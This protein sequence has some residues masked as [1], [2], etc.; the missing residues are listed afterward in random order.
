MLRWPWTGNLGIS[1]ESSDS[2]KID[3]FCVVLELRR[4]PCPPHH[5]QTPDHDHDLSTTQINTTNNSHPGKS[6]NPPGISRNW[7]RI[8]DRIASFLFKILKLSSF[9]GWLP[10]TTLPKGWMWVAAWP[11]SSFWLDYMN[12]TGARSGFISYL[13]LQYLWSEMTCSYRQYEQL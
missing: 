4:T 9:C 10:N 8:T 11:T 12:I 13:A 6:L 1:Q 5:Q 7:D 2:L 3:N